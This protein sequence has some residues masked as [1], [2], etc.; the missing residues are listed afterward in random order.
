MEAK[1]VIEFKNLINWAALLHTENGVYL[2]NKEIVG[3]LPPPLKSPGV[4]P[5]VV[6]YLSPC[7]P[8]LRTNLNQV[9][10]LFNLLSSSFSEM[11][12]NTWTVVDH[13]VL[14]A[15]FTSFLTWFHVTSG[16]LWCFCP[17]AAQVRR[18]RTQERWSET[19]REG[20]EPCSHLYSSTCGSSRHSLKTQPI[21]SPHLL[22]REGKWLRGPPLVGNKDWMHMLL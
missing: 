19:S 7:I 1:I 6:T 12:L 4:N 10:T 8:S 17:S 5:E 21:I 2:T 3:D 14:P 20:P 22:Y 16:S 11:H 9:F 18:W 13:P 15:V